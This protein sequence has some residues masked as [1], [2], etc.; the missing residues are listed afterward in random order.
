MNHI[1]QIGQQQAVYVY[2]ITEVAT[3]DTGAREGKA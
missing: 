2:L 1:N 3:A